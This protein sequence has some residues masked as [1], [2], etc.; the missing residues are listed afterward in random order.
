MS[1]SAM[2]DNARYAIPLA[3][4]LVAIALAK[5]AARNSRPPL[6]PGPTP[7]PIVG[8]MLTVNPTEPW[9]TYTEWGKAYGDIIYSRLLN[10]EIIVINSEKV[11]RD[12]LDHRSGNFSDRPTIVTT[13]FFGW[14]YNTGFMRYGDRWRQHRRLFHRVFKPEVALAYRPLQMRKVHQCLVGLIETPK[15]Y[16][17]LLQT[18]SASV[19]MAITYG[20]D[21]APRHDPL[22]AV[23]ESAITLAL[24][25]ITPE[26][27]AILSAYPFLLR[28]P[29]WFPGAGFQTKAQQSRDV[30]I[31]M[32]E[33][34][35]RHAKQ[36]I[37]SNIPISCVCSDL[38]SKA[39][40]EDDVNLEQAIKDLA[41]TSFV[42]AAETTSSTLLVFVLAMLLHPE[43]QKKAQ[44]EID[45]VVGQGR[46][47]DFDDRASMPYIDA[48]VRET[49]RWHPVVPLGIAHAAT[50]S[51]V[52]EGYHIPKGATV[53]ANAWAMS[54]NE[55][56]YPDPYTFKPE[57]F[58]VNGE[59]NDD[60]AI[61]AFG[62]G[63]RI[64]VG[65]HVADATVWAA[66]ASILAAF[67]IKK[68]RD[69]HGNEI[70]IDMKFSLEMIRHPLPLPCYF[71]SRLPG[72]TTEKLVQMI[73]TAE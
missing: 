63:R 33:A 3:V 53:I 29:S 42:A 14:S 36:C 32:V 18:L 54:H 20:Y 30:S 64:C 9:I 5:R 21:T 52:Y 47:P 39:S 10:Q 34:P 8:N 31:E 22:V 61:Y 7:L 55:D 67:N 11:A 46:L 62:F 73:A 45:A 66:I 70:E 13:E 27:A 51:D 40:N 43:I 59:L 37:S 50:E 2:V 17:S 26:A 19:I 28:L 60:T 16:D 71:E 56:K 58:L 69:E 49:L 12:L 41:A 57:R 25:A 24:G 38:L 4:L 23:V 72:M 6:P 1:A 15:E 35:F 48:I 44:V 65:R 68:D